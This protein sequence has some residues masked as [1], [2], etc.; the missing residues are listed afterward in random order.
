MINWIYLNVDP[1][2]V[3]SYKFNQIVG[4][5]E[6]V[7]LD[8]IAI[9]NTSMGNIVAEA[10]TIFDWVRNNFFEAL[11]GKGF[12]GGLN[13][14]R[15]YLATYVGAGAGYSPLDLTRNQFTRLHL[16]IFEVICKAGLIGTIAYIYLLLSLFKQK[17]IFLFSYFIILLLV[18][19]NSKEM[20]LLSMIF[21][22]MAINVKS[23]YLK[24]Q[25][26]NNVN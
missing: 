17:N 24:K 6:I 19:S 11:L 9:S 18:F 15:G 12:G 8:I 7:D 16:P 14:S 3:I 10:L 13:D 26:L 5:F 20:I 2:L 4:I 25:Y 21:N 23:P 1:G 22:H